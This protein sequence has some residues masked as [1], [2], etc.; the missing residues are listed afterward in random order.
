[1][2]IALLLAT[3][4]SVTNSATA[5]TGGNSASGG[6]VTTGSASASAGTS[7]S[8]SSGSGGTS[9][10]TSVSATANGKTQSETKTE[11]VKPGEDVQVTSEVRASTGGQTPGNITAATA[12]PESSADRTVS[13]RERSETR[14]GKGESATSSNEV[15]AKTPATESR[16][17]TS[18]I[19]ARLS[20]FMGRLFGFFLFQ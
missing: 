1:M 4:I 9:V 2:F 20:S 3:T 14:D 6:T 19:V 7:V 10:T 11:E 16:S 8:G 5:D 13:P 18:R 12:S 15:S 17:Y